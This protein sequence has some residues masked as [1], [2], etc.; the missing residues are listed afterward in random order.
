MSENLLTVEQAAARLGVKVQT[1][2]AYV[3]RGLLARAGRSTARRT[4]FHPDD[5]DDL[6]YRRRRRPFD[7]HGLPSVKTRLTG[8]TDG[9]LLYRDR[10][11]CELARNRPFE[12]VCELLWSGADDPAPRWPQPRHF[13]QA[14][15]LTGLAAQ[16]RICAEA[17]DARPA[18]GTI[19]SAEGVTRCGRELIQSFAA[20]GRAQYCDMGS[21]A[22]NLWRQLSP[23]VPTPGRLRV[24]NAALILVADHDLTASTL[25]VRVAAATRAHPIAAVNAGLN[26]LD[27]SYHGAASIRVLDFLRSSRLQEGQL[28][29]SLTDYVP[30]LPRLPGFGHRLHPSGDPRAACLLSMMREIEPAHPGWRRLDEL[31]TYIRKRGWGHPNIDFALAAMGFLYDWPRD[32]GRTVFAIGRTGGWLAHAIEEY[33]EAPDRFRPRGVYLGFE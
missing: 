26:I 6:A 30:P 9:T 4:L 1:L 15:G 31:L 3:S 22:A 19:P 23:L 7:E 21:V 33:E 8:I 32:G 13:D 5:V 28:T 12:S 24:L 29:E 18:P 17:R 20:A 10:D 16:L 14:V 27:G 25:V 2:Y 11:A